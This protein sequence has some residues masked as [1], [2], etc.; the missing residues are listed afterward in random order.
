MTH[1][2]TDFFR[3]IGIDESTIPPNVEVTL[4][5][6]A[7]RPYIK[8]SVPE[9][10]PKLFCTLTFMDAKLKGPDSDQNLA[11]RV[12]AELIRHGAKAIRKENKV[13]KS[14]MSC[15]PVKGGSRH[16]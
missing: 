16:P 14:R 7:N 1:R 5:Q 15:P 3:K 6:N 2:L 4:I 10:G 12:R 11:E 8:L 13:I 9:E